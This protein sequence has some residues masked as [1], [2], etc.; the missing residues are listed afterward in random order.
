MKS[1]VPILFASSVL[2]F[3]GCSIYKTSALG[4]D[5]AKAKAAGAPILIYAIGVPGQIPVRG[6]QTAVPVYIQFLVAAKQPI[7]RI[8]FF[9][10]AYSQ[11][12]HPVLNQQGQHLEMV[13]IGPGKFSPGGNYEVNSLHSTP[14]GFPGGDVACVELKSMVLTYSNGEKQNFTRQSLL[15]AILPPLR[16]HCRDKGPRVDSMMSSASH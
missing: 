14:A 12:G 16:H 6:T 10:T 7:Q 3:T 2:V 8:R 11:R 4:P 9:F 13:L 1:I 15:N 5:L